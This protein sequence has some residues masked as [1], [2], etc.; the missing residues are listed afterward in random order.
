MT[1]SNNS[2]IH[3]YICFFFCFI[4]FFEGRVEATPFSCREVLAENI[5]LRLVGA[6]CEGTGV[7]PLF[8][9]FQVNHSSSIIKLLP[10][11]SSDSKEVPGKKADCCCKGG[12][13]KCVDEE[14]R[15]VFSSLVWTVVGCTVAAGVLKFYY[16]F[17]V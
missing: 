12:M 2:F 6:G 15:H 14:L 3:A 13:G 7:S 1:S 5:E 11:V 17:V 4:V 16:S 9:Q 10:P 8:N